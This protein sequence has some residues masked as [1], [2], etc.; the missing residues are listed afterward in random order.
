MERGMVKKVLNVY[1][2]RFKLVLVGAVA[3]L[4][5]L[6]WYNRFVQDDACICFRYA[7]NLAEGAGLVWNQGQRIEGYTNFLWTVA[8][9]GLLRL[10]VGAVTASYAL[11]LL[12]FV[13]SLILVYRTT[14]LLLRSADLG[15]L[16]VVL[17]GT[18]YSFSRYATGGLETQMQCCLCLAAT[19]LALRTVRDGPASRG[20]L[21]LSS[22]LAAAALMTRLGDP[23]CQALAGLPDRG[24]GFFKTLEY[25]FLHACRLPGQ[26]SATPYHTAV[27]VGWKPPVGHAG[28]IGRTRRMMR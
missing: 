14:L 12:A 7:R 3:S 4:T 16:V 26:R 24:R 5:L 27:S 19:Y 17:A 1:R 2:S 13:V 23:P 22:V 9:G 8:I 28:L 25:R 18:N 10:G 6:A 15:L 21:V 20:V 11:G